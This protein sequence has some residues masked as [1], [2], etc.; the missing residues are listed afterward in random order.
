MAGASGGRDAMIAAD[1]DL[2]QCRMVSVPW[3]SGTEVDTGHV[4]ILKKTP[5]GTLV[6]RRVGDE[7]GAEY[8]F[9][10]AEHRAKFVQAEKSKFFGSSTRMPT[11]RCSGRLRRS[12]TV[13]DIASQQRPPAVLIRRPPADMLPVGSSRPVSGRLTA[14]CQ[15]QAPLGTPQCLT[16]LS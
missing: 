8:R 7:G 10:W 5:S 12:A 4:V 9:K 16:L 2:P 14:S 15:L 11:R 1:V 3:R 6:A 13:M